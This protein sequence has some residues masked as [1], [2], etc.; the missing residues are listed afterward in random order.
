MTVDAGT[1]VGAGT[2]TD[3]GTTVSTGRDVFIVC[4]TIDELGGVQSWARR[5]AGLLA[6]RGHRVRL[7]GVFAVADA[8]RTHR[9]ASSDTAHSDTAH[10]YTETLLH[11]NRHGARPRPALLSRIANPVAFLRYKRWESV[12]RAGASR[13][14]ALLATA[15]QPDGAVVI[16]AQVHAMEW[17][18]RAARIRGRS[19][20][21]VI[22]MSHESYAASM[23]STR[24]RRVKKLYATAARFVCLTE[25]DAARWVHEGGMNNTAVVPNP[26]P[27][28]AN[29]GAD[30]GARVVV[31]LGRLSQE[32]GFDLLLESWAEATARRPG[33][34]LRMYGSGPELSALTAQAERLGITAS[35][36]FAGQTGDVAA[37]LVQGSIFAAP[38]RAEGFPM[39]LLE[40]MACGVPCVAFDCA[41]GVREIVH[42]GE[43][44]VVVPPGNTDAFAESLGALMDAREERE[45][46]GKAAVESVAR[47]APARIVARW[48][49]LFDLVRR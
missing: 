43:D 8:A 26:L 39:V 46:L 15:D 22:A 29:G 20:P 1:T 4:N 34:T 32:K 49:S 17:V 24:G 27:F 35:V 45:S 21:P 9:A 23:A 11:P 12:Q 14:A 6:E 19:A 30:A 10:T 38:S 37:A 44:G 36:D 7:V 16:C 18:S 33:W 41:P 28:P 2:T 42:D 13:L 25:A 3:T 5:V 31:A 48:E 47:F 40:A